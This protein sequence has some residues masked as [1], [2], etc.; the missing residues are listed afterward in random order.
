ME[1]IEKILMKIII[2][3]FL[4]LLLTQFFLHQLDTLPELQ[5]LTKYEGVNENSITE[6]LQTFQGN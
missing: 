6:I 5:Q 3:Q 2:I 4:F 1:K